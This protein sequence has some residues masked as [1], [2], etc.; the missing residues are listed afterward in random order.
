M[1]S[2]DWLVRLLKAW[3]DAAWSAIF[4]PLQAEAVVA[5]CA[6]D[7]LPC[8]PE[9]DSPMASAQSRRVATQVNK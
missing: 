1:S 7:D 3:A 8:V 2:S 4:A 9:I 5:R 6:V